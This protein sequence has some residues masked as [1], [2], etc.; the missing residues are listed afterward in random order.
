MPEMTGQELVREVLALRA[1]TP[2][3]M[4]TGFSPL[5]DADNAKAAGVRAFAM[6]PLTKTELATT[7][8]K[9]LDEWVRIELS[10]PP[11]SNT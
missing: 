11:T 7:V 1:D 9:V 8:R 10:I 5:V 2:V 6:K 4:C 3:I